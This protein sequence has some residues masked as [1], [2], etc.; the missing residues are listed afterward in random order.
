[1]KKTK[2]TSAKIL[3]VTNNIPALKSGMGKQYIMDNIAVGQIFERKDSTKVIVD[4]IVDTRIILKV[5]DLDGNKTSETRI[6]SKILFADCM[7]NK[8]FEPTAIARR[9]SFSDCSREL[10]LRQNFK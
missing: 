1:M 6:F 9:E 8:Q 2:I 7:V 5:L 10:S 3:K 4:E